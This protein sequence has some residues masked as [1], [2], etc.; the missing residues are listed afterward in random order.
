M[1]AVW[2]DIELGTR[3]GIFL[4]SKNN[5]LSLND[6][7]ILD[8]VISCSTRFMSDDSLQFYMLNGRS[9][10]WVLDILSSIT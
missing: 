3:Q 6:I 10:I 4:I 5:G 9:L 1:L 8:F 2:K 7:V